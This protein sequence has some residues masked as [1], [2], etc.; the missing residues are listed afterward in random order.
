MKRIRLFAA[1]SLVFAVSLFGD[2]LPVPAS[3]RSTVTQQ[4]GKTTVTVD[5]SRPNMKG[6]EIFGALVPYGEVWRTG[7]NACTKLSTDTEIQ[8]G[9]STLP[10]GRYGLFSIPNKDQWTIIINANA[11]QFGA[12]TYDDALDVLRF[13]APSKS[14]QESFETFEIAFAQVADN[15]ARIELRWDETVVAFPISVTEESNH[16][17]MMS[18]IRKE[19]IE[20]DNPHWAN[21]GEAARYFVRENMDLEQ[22][23]E[24]YRLSLEQNP[25]A[26]WLAVERSKVLSALDQPEEAKAVMQSALDTAQRLNDAQGIAWIEG[27]LA[28]L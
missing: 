27:E 10:A 1:L 3:L 2:V 4:I 7:A 28:K 23:A 6:R 5:Y 24:W 16:Q 15:A 13:T 22:A 17:Q 9:G 11:D 20:A 8:I 12:F 26:Y 21:M 19:V 14:M 18:D 25:D